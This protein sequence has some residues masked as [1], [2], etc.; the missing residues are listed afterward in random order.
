MGNAVELLGVKEQSAGAAYQR[1][2]P[3]KA[4]KGIGFGAGAPGDDAERSVR[5]H[6]CVRTHVHLSTCG[7]EFTGTHTHTHT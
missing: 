6:T 5:T 3:L 7:R 2:G 1:E 4:E